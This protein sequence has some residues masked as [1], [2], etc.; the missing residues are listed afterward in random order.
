MYATFTLNASNVMQQGA[1]APS[2]GF[3]GTSLLT[4]GVVSIAVLGA[5]VLLRRR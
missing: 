4:I 2:S 1:A 3:C 5:I